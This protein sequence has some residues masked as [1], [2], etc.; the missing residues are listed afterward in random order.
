MVVFGILVVKKEYFMDL[1]IIH[2]GSFRYAQKSWQVRPH[3]FLGLYVSGLK[4]YKSSHCDLRPENGPAVTLSFKGEASS[5]EFGPDRENWVVQYDSSDIRPYPKDPVKVLVSWGRQNILLPRTTFVKEEEVDVWRSQFEQMRLLMRRPD[6][7]ALVL[8]KTFFVRV[9]GL[10]I[11]RAG[12][13]VDHSPAAVL[14]RLL[15]NVENV[16][17]PLGELS[18]QLGYC[19]QHLRRLFKERYGV[20]PKAY[21]QRKRLEFC[22]DLLKNSNLACKEIAG[23]AGFEHP[24]QFTKSFRKVYGAS[25]REF[26]SATRGTASRECSGCA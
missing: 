24:A 23:M 15:D 21:R 7:A 5:F 12:A 6:D 25:P 10:L 8:C 22:L 19:P 11:E 18:R 26:R 16:Q 4:F 1:E 14:R 9:I 20:A 17:V 2:A 3:H 13:S